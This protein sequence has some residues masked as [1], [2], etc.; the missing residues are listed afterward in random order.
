MDRDEY[1][2]T[3]EAGE[4]AA[5]ETP[6]EP[7]VS[8]LTEEAPAIA[9]PSDAVADGI[10]SA[11]EGPTA[12]A[13]APV[14][15]EA[16]ELPAPQVVVAEEASADFEP[17]HVIEALLFASDAPLSAARLAELAGAGTAGDVRKHI[18]ILNAKYAAVG[19]SFRIEEI[20]RGYQMLTLPAYQP[21]L[22]KLDKHRGQNRLT[23]AALETL[24]IVAYKQPVIRA[25]VEAIRGVA[26]GEVLNRLREMGLVKIMGRAE[27]VGRPILYGTTR[28]FLDVFGLADL[29]DLPPMESLLLRKAPARNADVPPAAASEAEADMPVA[30]AG[31]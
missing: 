15:A 6:A 29:E 7:T 20:A 28:K 1:A 27:I 30:A 16:A 9:A 5:L 13:E 8:P 17:A 11:T 19:V 26:C 22:A 12:T 10:P 23:G 24:S 4:A 31:A 18:E 14:S 3:V 25:D 2:L 21:W